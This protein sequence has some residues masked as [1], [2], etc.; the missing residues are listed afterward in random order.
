M[1]NLGSLG[2]AFVDV[3]ADLK[4]LEKDLKGAQQKLGKSLT[5]MGQTMTGLGTNLTLGLTAPI[6]AL[7]AATTKMASS[8]E[9]EMTKIETLVGRPREEVEM[10]NKEVLKMAGEVGKAPQELAEALFFVTSAGIQGGAAL[11]VLKNAAK[12]SAIGLGETK[13]VADAVTS[14][15]N[16]YG[17]SNLSA[18]RATEILIATVRLG[19]LEASELAGS[20]G[21]VIGI[22]N[23]VGVSF[24]DVGTF[25][26]SF[27]RVGVSAEEAVTALRGTLAQLIKPA[28]QSKEVFDGLGY[29]A[30]QLKQD[31]AEKGLARAFV[32]L[33]A[34]VKATS[35]STSEAEEKLGML[36]P[37]I[38]ALSGVLATAGSQAETF[39][40]ISDQMNESVG[41]LDEGFARVQEDADQMMKEVTAAL[42]AISVELGGAFL[43]M[44]KNYFIPALDK[45]VDLLGV[46]VDGFKALP[47]PIQGVVFGLGLLLAALGPIITVAGILVTTFGQIVLFLGSFGGAATGAG[48]AAGAA[49]VGVKWL[50]GAVLGLGGVL[51]TVA[52]FLTGPWGLAIIAASALIIYFKDDVADLIVAFLEWI[53][54][55]E[56]AEAQMKR[57]G[58]VSAE[59]SAGLKGFQEKVGL[60]NDELKGLTGSLE[61][62][63]TA[64]SYNKQ[65]VMEL[66]AQYKA[67]TLSKEEYLAALKKVLEENKRVGDSTTKVGDAAAGA[68][69]K[70]D[71]LGGALGGLGGK[72]KYTKEE[73]DGVRDSINA[74]LDPFSKLATEL[75]KAMAAG[76]T[77]EQFVAAFA[78]Q[79]LNARDRVEELNPALAAL[80]LESV[81]VNEELVAMAENFI[82]AA[83]G[84]ETMAEKAERAQLV[85]KS[86]GEILGDLEAIE[87][88]ADISSRNLAR[89]LVTAGDDT[90]KVQRIVDLYGLSLADIEK[91][92]KDGE[93]ALQDNEKA[94]LKKAK[95]YLEA[96]KKTKDLADAHDVLTKEVADYRNKIPNLVKKIKDYEAAGADAEFITEK[97]GQEIIDTTEALASQGEEIPEE[98]S[99]YYE[100]A[101]A[102]EAATAA[103]ERAARF[104][105]QWEDAWSTAIGNVVGGFIDGLDKILFEGESFS[106]DLIGIFKD[107]GRTLLKIVIGQIFEPILGAAAQ[108]GANLGQSIMGWLGIGKGPAGGLFGGVVDMFTG[109]SKGGGLTNVAGSL[110]GGVFAG[111]GGAPGA[112]PPSLIASLFPDKFVPPAAPGV[113]GGFGSTVTGA[114]SS[115]GAGIKT[116]MG[117]LATNPVGWAILGGLGIFGAYKKWFSKDAIKSGVKEVERDFSV[118]VSKGILEGF[119][120]GMSISKDQFEDFRKYTLG[121]P[122][123]FEQMLLPAAQSQGKV[124]ELIRAFGE[125]RLQETFKPNIEAAGL[126]T[127]YGAG[128]FFVD[129][130]EQAREAVEGNFAALNE[131]WLDIFSG[132]GMEQAFGDLSKFLSDT[133]AEAEAVEEA[134]ST[135][136]E[137]LEDLGTE[138]AE[139]VAGLAEKIAEQ[140]E[141][142]ATAF[143]SMLERLDAIIEALGGSLE[144]LSEKLVQLVDQMTNLQDMQE[145]VTATQ[146]E[147]V[148]EMGSGG[149]GTVNFHLTSIDSKGVKE[150]VEGEAMDYMIDEFGM[151]RSEELARIVDKGRG[152]S[153]G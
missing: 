140:T 26:A 55:A 123:A 97:F 90:K 125:F 41:I 63:I 131:A 86:F 149:G 127:G 136:E 59:G 117:F 66:A 107:L 62:T 39:V 75:E 23:Q 36:I 152:V 109:G 67:G 89:A 61:K 77:K 5:Q 30:A 1:P 7:G 28:S 145:S 15:V 151:R 133:V 113:A 120:E 47:E 92:L 71:G 58:S 8:F 153:G 3:R 21:R 82:D 147:I 31:I 121:S 87:K 78:E 40:D 17:E 25:V 19:K 141:M 6:V 60:T 148:G 11:D 128:G 83:G 65:A 29:S 124:D 111:G 146:A 72:A 33:V 94:A 27:T 112:M 49:A 52:A 44:L 116:G 73:L 91:A 37:N 57:L 35:G 48:T 105:K 24:E 103:Q 144:K 122:Q 135:A 115:I 118:T 42:K 143:E 13:D 4:G 32:D 74:S 99:L 18:K 138:G 142:M 132:T 64:M 22:A 102:Q 76:F 95:A 69:P 43:P 10:F 106:M 70:V 110:L 34:H 53:G 93:G 45:F 51:K 119:L 150:F 56:S 79:I 137:G 96:K 16:A 108:F 98:I 130:S 80:G 100:M 81:T 101:K 104:A 129:L 50:A 114:L 46:L 12:A 14:A 38:R 88:K 126:K 84:A 54:V 139:A 9:S 2:E 85:I 134:S 20:L 68:T